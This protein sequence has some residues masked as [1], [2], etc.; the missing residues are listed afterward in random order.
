MT[1]PIADMLT[2]MRNALMRKH[3][4][5]VLP[6][7]N[8]K[9]EIARILKEEDLIRDY[10]VVEEAGNKKALK[11]WLKYVDK[12]EP[13]ISGLKRISKPGRRVYIGWDSVPL[14]KAGLGVS[15]LSTSKGVMTDKASR[16]MK[17]GGE[18]LCSVW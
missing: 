9:G 7:S 6:H 2:Q 10:K 18:L 8:L 4:G 5:V 14:V 1:D 13:V 3:R 16:A 15:I 12:E 17:I 11:I